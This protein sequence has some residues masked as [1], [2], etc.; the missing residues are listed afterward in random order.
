MALAAYGTDAQSTVQENE[1]I[2]AL[3]GDRSSRLVLDKAEFKNSPFFN[4]GVE[5]QSFKNLSK[6]FSHVLF[7]KF[8]SFASR[9]LRKG[10]SIIPRERQ[11]D[12]WLNIGVAFPHEDGKGFNVMLQALP[13]HGNGKIVLRE[14]EAKDGD[15]DEPPAGERRNASQSRNGG[16]RGK[17]RSQRPG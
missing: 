6:R 14:H 10:Y 16:E 2:E 4:I 13:M 1:L 11:D 8:F 5:S 7:E 15:T 12:Y 3:I 9:H 17:S